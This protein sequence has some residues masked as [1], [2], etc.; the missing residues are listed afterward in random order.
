MDRALDGVGIQIRMGS[1]RGQGGFSLLQLLI[2]ITIIGII[3]ALAILNITSARANIRLQNAGRKLASQVEKARLDA[4]RRHDT[5]SVQFTSLTTYTVNMD[6]DGSGTK[7]TRTFT[8]ENGT[9]VLDGGAAV[10]LP[11]INFNWRGRSDKCLVTFAIATTGSNADPLNVDVS[12]SGD[13]TLNSEL[14]ETLPAINYNAINN[15][16]G[17][18]SGS[19]IVGTATHNNGSITGCTA[20][21]PTSTPT[22]SP[23][24]AGGSCGAIQANYSAV[25]VKKNGGSSVSLT[26]N[27]NKAAT[28]TATYTSNLS[29]T[30][31]SSTVIAG[32]SSTF[33]VKSINTARGQYTVSFSNGCATV[34]VIV[35]VVK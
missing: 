14:A 28:L 8:L 22:S 3:S 13:V 32:G 27:S 4:I 11:S 35:T 6:F 23:I 24:S 25:T 30:P 12:G 26:I 15:T 5:S 29:V 31:A 17:I 34:S 10:A 16:N 20:G 9:A 19:T 21:D 18:A 7:T 33:T 1:L 2:T